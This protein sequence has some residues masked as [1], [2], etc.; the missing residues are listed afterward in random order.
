MRNVAVMPGGK[1]FHNFTKLMQTHTTEKLFFE[2]YTLSNAVPF[3]LGL[4]LVLS[5]GKAVLVKDSTQTPANSCAEHSPS[6]NSPINGIFLKRENSHK[7]TQ[8]KHSCALF[9]PTPRSKTP[10]C[11]PLPA[12][13]SFPF[14]D[15]FCS[16]ALNIN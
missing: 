5:I 14:Y 6:L 8:L 9:L 16:R 10:A 13:E 2:D 12:S 7:L 11:L 3:F 15:M 4:E 1:H